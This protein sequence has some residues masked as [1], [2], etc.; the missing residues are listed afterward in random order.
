MQCSGLLLA[1]PDNLGVSSAVLGWSPLV[2]S[3]EANTF[4]A[5]LYEFLSRRWEPLADFSSARTRL[6]TLILKEGK[7]DNL[8][9]LGYSC[10]SWFHCLH[11]C[12][13]FELVEW[14]SAM[15]SRILGLLPAVLSELCGAN[16]VAV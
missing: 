16:R 1:L 11:S 14:F 4:P 5:V 9:L 12:T 8:V 15:P 3:V 10:R 6:C 7:E 13:E 2:S